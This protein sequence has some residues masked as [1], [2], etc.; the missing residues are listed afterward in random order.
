VQSKLL[1]AEE[2]TI[3][4]RRGR[5]RMAASRH[6]Q[7]HGDVERRRADRDGRDAGA[8]DP[9][10][11]RGARGRS[12]P[13]PTGRTGCADRRD[14]H[15]PADQVFTAIGQTL[16]AAPEALDFSGGKIA[17]TG[18]AAPRSRGLGRGRLRGGRR[19]PDGDR[20]RRGPRRGRGWT[21]MRR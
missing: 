16:E 9:G 14:L 21:S 5:E 15:L 20:R 7:E 1:G 10:Q 2:V 13:M 19:G 4:Y 18:R 6:E 8:R 17:V 3:V 12:S 11:W